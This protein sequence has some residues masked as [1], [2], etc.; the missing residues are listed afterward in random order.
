M[1]KF[2]SVFH[3]G[4][5]SA[6]Y[7]SGANSY[8][9]SDHEDYPASSKSSYKDGSAPEYSEYEKEEVVQYS[10]SVVEEE[11]YDASAISSDLGTDKDESEELSEPARRQIK[12]F[13]YNEIQP[14]DGELEST[15]EEPMN[16]HPKDRRKEINREIDQLKRQQT[17]KTCI[18]L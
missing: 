17:S 3:N 8:N 1:K 18:L 12:G 4:N 10:T 15:N 2:P 14:D 11:S 13:K 7:S 9:T 16:F 5:M 6:D